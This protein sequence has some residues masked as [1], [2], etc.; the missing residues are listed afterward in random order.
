MTAREISKFQYSLPTEPIVLATAV[1]W[2]PLD[3]ETCRFPNRS[4]ELLHLSGDGK[5]REYAR[6]VP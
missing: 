1:V 3:A 5:R 2:H 6:S 4:R